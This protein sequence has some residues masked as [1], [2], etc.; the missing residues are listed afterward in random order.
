VLPTSHFVQRFARLHT[1]RRLAQNGCGA[2]AARRRSIDDNLVALATAVQ[3]QR[4]GW[5]AALCGIFSLS[6]AFRILPAYAVRIAAIGA[7]VKLSRTHNSRRRAGSPQG[8][9]SPDVD[10]VGSCKSVADCW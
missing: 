8:Y 4:C 7:T 6:D 2:S 9:V 1:G 3:Q 5:L 10:I